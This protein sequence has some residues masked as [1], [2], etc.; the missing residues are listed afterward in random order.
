MCSTENII[1]ISRV[2]DGIE[3]VLD[4][5]KGV[6]KLKEGT[7]IG[8]IYIWKDGSWYYGSSKN[9]Y[10]DGKGILLD[11]V[12]PTVFSKYIGEFRNGRSS[13]YGILRNCD[14]EFYRGNWMNGMRHGYGNTYFVDGTVETGYYNNGYQD[15]WFQYTYPKTRRGVAGITCLFNM[16]NIVKYGEL[17]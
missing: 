1:D 15:G 10:P 2:V 4:Y 11:R 7:Y 9:G 17:L 5:K 6:Y 13:G 3:R 12:S 16:G 14:G 8:D